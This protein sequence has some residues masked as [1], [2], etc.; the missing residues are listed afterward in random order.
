MKPNQTAATALWFRTLHQPSFLCGPLGLT[1]RE[2]PHTVNE[3]NI[4]NT[5]VSIQETR[6]NG[7][8]RWVWKWYE[9]WDGVFTVSRRMV[10][11]SP[12]NNLWQGALKLFWRLVVEWHLTNT[13][14]GFISYSYLYVINMMH[15]K[16]NLLFYRFWVGATG[17]RMFYGSFSG[18]SGHS[19]G[20]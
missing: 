9:S 19:R 16:H 20:P 15:N 11:I 18:F 4:T 12:V 7:G 14:G 10:L 13:L 8:V 17:R 5:A 3:W 1:K 6:P 2:N